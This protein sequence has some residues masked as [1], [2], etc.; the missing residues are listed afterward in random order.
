MELSFYTAHPTPECALMV[1]QLA[2]ALKRLGRGGVLRIADDSGSEGS[3][4]DQVLHGAQALSPY[5]SFK[6]ALEA[7]GL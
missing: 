7:C 2:H 1:L 3:Y 6:A 5:H 4:V